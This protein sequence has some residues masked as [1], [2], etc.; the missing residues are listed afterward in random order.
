[1]EP[2]QTH[3][4]NEVRKHPNWNEWVIMEPFRGL[5]WVRSLTGNTEN[6]KSG[7]SWNQPNCATADAVAGTKCHDW[8]TAKRIGWGWDG[9]H[10]LGTHA[11]QHTTSMRHE[12]NSCGR[13]TGSRGRKGKEWRRLCEWAAEKCFLLCKKKCQCNQKTYFFLPFHSG[14]S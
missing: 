4:Q 2:Q 11:T 9:E 3:R 5:W 10:S 1:M 14:S 6:G 7:G 12:E 8:D 13:D